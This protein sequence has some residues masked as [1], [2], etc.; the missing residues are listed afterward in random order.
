L[1]FPIIQVSDCSYFFFFAMF[2]LLIKFWS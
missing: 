1:E 2:V